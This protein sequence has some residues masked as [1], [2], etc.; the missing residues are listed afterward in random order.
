MIKKRA[1]STR[2]LRVWSQ[3]LRWIPKLTS[4]ET[5]CGT[6][7]CWQRVHWLRVRLLLLHTYRSRHACRSKTLI[8]NLRSGEKTIT[9]GSKVRH[10]FTTGHRNKRRIVQLKLFDESIRREKRWQSRKLECWVAV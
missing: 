6:C 1:T 9:N 8:R 10:P 4:C 2:Q 3:F 7:Y 5:G